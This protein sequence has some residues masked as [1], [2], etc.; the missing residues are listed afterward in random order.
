VTHWLDTAPLR[1][2][3]PNIAS[4]LKT[5]SNSTWFYHRSSQPHVICP[6]LALGLTYYFKIQK[7]RRPER[8]QQV[9]PS[10]HETTL[11]LVTT[12]SKLLSRR[13][14]GTSSALFNGL[15]TLVGTQTHTPTYSL[16][17]SLHTLSQN[18][19][20]LPGSG[21]GHGVAIGTI[22]I[23]SNTNTKS[24]LQSTTDIN[25]GILLHLQVPPLL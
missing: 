5:T 9:E 19:A 11:I 21:V 14:P 4:D 7:A 13:Q 2:T 25:I 24:C 16:T 10:V 17:P 1:L 3:P 18:G 12:Y 22:A 15:D 8:R 6:K 20:G 23:T